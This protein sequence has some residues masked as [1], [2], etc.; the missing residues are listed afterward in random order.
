MDDTTKCPFTGGPRAHANQR[1]RD[2]RRLPFLGE[3]MHGER[4]AVRAV[5]TP[6]SLVGDEMYREDTVP[7][8]AGASPV[9]VRRRRVARRSRELAAIN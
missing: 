8:L 4:A 1:S 3:G 9:V 7:Q 2:L 5:G 6:G